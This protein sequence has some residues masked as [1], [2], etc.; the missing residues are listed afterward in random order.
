VRAGLSSRAYSWTHDVAP[1]GGKSLLSAVPSPL[2]YPLGIARRA[3][4]KVG[5]PPLE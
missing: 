4:L 5:S 1:R 3:T 2:P